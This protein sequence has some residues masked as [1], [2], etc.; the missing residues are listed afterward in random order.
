MRLR[1]TD[2][3]LLTMLA[4]L[5]APREAQAIQGTPPQVPPHTGTVPSWGI[6]R[7]VLHTGPPHL[8]EHTGAV[9][10]RTNARCIRRWGDRAP[11]FRLD[12]RTMFLI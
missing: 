3:G 4:W 8:V 6:P 5:E 10:W 9:A 1:G 12:K 11:Y 7:H 2:A